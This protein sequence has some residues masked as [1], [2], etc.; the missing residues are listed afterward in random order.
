MKSQLDVERLNT[1]IKMQEQMPID[2]QSQF[3]IDDNLLHTN[4][5]SYTSMDDHHH[6]IA[7][8][9]RKTNNTGGRGSHKK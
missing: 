3:L 8:L 6:L 1:L 4:E 9:D 2:K 5:E 7:E